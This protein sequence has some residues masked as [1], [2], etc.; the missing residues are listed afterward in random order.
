MF[1]GFLSVACLMEQ[2]KR[3][4]E[5]TDCLSPQPHRPRRAAH[6][7]SSNAKKITEIRNKIYNMPSTLPLEW[8]TTNERKRKGY[9]L[10]TAHSLRCTS[11]LEKATNIS[12]KAPSSRTGGLWWTRR[13][14]ESAEGSC[15]CCVSTVLVH[16]SPGPCRTLR[17]RQ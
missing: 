2:V 17:A 12:R 7:H 13:H 8:T 6:Q 16:R 5:G 10:Y 15:G 1:G 11:L 4:V 9:P 3:Q 14:S